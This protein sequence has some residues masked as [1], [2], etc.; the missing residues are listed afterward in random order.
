VHFPGR[1]ESTWLLWILVRIVAQVCWGFTQVVCVCVNFLTK[2]KFESLWEE[3]GTEG[4]C[5]KTAFRICFQLP[6]AAVLPRKRCCLPVC[7]GYISVVFSFPAVV[8]YYSVMLVGHFVV[9]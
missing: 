6:E 7:E 5:T 4:L 8:L 9:S 1:D 3:E 2:R